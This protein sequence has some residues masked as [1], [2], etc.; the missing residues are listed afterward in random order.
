MKKSLITAALVMT[1]A[2][3]LGAMAGCSSEPA[4]ADVNAS[5]PEGAAPLM[6]FLLYTSE[7]FYS[8]FS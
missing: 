4:K 7:G 2:A 3:G 8:I 1:M 6:P 5:I